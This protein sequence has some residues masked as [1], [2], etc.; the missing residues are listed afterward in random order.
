V[1]CRGVRQKHGG[2]SR[3]DRGNQVSWRSY[4]DILALHKSANRY[5]GWALL[6]RVEE[7]SANDSDMYVFTN[8][9]GVGSMEVNVFQR[10]C[11][12]VIQNSLR[13]GF[14]LVVFEALWKETPV[15]AGRAGGIPMQVPP[16][17]ERCL[18]DRVAGCASRSCIYSSI[19]VS[20]GRLSAPDGSMYANI[21]CCRDWCLISCG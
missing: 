11:D 2:V 4:Y 20:E 16:G 5:K 6:D 21:F 14:G 1:A 7:E 13:E 9:G 12:A 15:V 8:L 19:R 17:F 10:G 3:D 18:V